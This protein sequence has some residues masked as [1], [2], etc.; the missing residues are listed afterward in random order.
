MPI[1]QMPDGQLVDM[2]DNPTPEQLKQLQQMAPGQRQGFAEA[3]GEWETVSVRP[4]RWTRG[5][6]FLRHRALGAS[7][8]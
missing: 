2:P 4:P 6:A 8:D 3:A 7:A 1:V 5:F